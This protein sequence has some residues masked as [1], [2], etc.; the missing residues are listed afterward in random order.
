MKKLKDTELDTIY[1]DFPKAFDTANYDILLKKLKL[2][3]VSRNFF[4]LD[5]KLSY[6]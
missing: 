4:N 1:T 2:L 3:G 6:R 5:K